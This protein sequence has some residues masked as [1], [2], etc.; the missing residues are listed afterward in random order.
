MIMMLITI[1]E[2]RRKLSEVC[3]LLCIIILT[4]TPEKNLVHKNAQLKSFS[5]HLRPTYSNL[6]TDIANVTKLVYLLM[7][8]KKH[9]RRISFEF[10]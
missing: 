7:T 4:T 1:T 5:Y 6:N 9:L 2:V 3:V 10:S 8:T